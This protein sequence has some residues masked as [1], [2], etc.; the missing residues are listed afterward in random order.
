MVTI[1][2]PGA[3]LLLRRSRSL[4]P[5]GLSLRCQVTASAPPPTACNSRPT[6]ARRP[7]PPPPPAPALAARPPPGPAW[8]GP[9]PRDAPVASPRATPAGAAAPPS[10]LPRGPARP[11]RP[12]PP[13]PA[14]P[15][16][17]L[18]AGA[19]GLRGER[20][21]C[22]WGRGCVR[23]SRR[24]P[25]Q[26]SVLAAGPAGGSDRAR[27]AQ[28]AATAPCPH[29]SRGDGPRDTPPGPGWGMSA[30]LV[31]ARAPVAHTRCIGAVVSLLTAMT[32]VER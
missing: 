21:R 10:W 1:P 7:A 17:R 2:L 32:A 6:C 8:P 13:A 26:G 22:P 11:G 27:L 18:S 24:P 4:S 15:C 14:R 16:L 30:H 20:G 25:P 5:L 28:N 3:P 9:G 29:L 19:V 23:A 12:S 31:G